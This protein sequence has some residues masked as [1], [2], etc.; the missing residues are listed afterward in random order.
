M[1][2][3]TIIALTALAV[4]FLLMLVLIGGSLIYVFLKAH[5]LIGQFEK[6]LKE[7][8]SEL[9]NQHEQSQSELKG[10]IAKINGEELNKAVSTFVT[11]MIEM[12]KF[13]TRAENAALAMGEMCKVI[14]S[15]SGMA[16]RTSYG[17]EEYALA[18]PGEGR[19][20]TQSESAKLDEAERGD[21]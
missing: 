18:E 14:V 7:Q 11:K 5:K 16:S 12:G 13:V 3:L 15:D 17:A 19:A 2:P 10:A 21:M 1:S 20:F 6:D 4:L 8:L 9:R